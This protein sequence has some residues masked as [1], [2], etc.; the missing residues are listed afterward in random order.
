MSAQDDKK[1]L[2]NTII[3]VEGFAL[4]VVGVFFVLKPQFTD[5]TLLDAELDFYLGCALILVAF[6]NIFIANKIFNYKKTK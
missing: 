5:F 4:F 2:L 3:R 6:T 1:K